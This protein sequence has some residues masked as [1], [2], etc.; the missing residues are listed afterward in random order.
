MSLCSRHKYLTFQGFRALGLPAR[1][2]T[3]P[4]YWARHAREAVQFSAAVTTLQ[5]N[6]AGA[7]LL[8]VG[9][10]VDAQHTSAATCERNHNRFAAR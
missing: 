9:P 8:E 4:L 3:D 2:A 7:V 5:K 10:G 6:E 1:Q